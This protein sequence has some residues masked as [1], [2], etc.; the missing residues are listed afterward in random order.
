MGGY[1]GLAP[2]PWLRTG[3]G[4]TRALPSRWLRH[5][6][7]SVLT[8]W[9]HERVGLHQ[10]SPAPDRAG[11]DGPEA[12]CLLVALCDSRPCAGRRCAE[13]LTGFAAAAIGC[14]RRS[15]RAANPV[16]PRARVPSQRWVPLSR[17]RMAHARG[18]SVRHP[19]G[20]DRIQGGA[21]ERRPES[22][23]AAPRSRPAECVRT[24]EI[25]LDTVNPIQGGGSCLLS[26]EANFPVIT[27]IR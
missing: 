3:S 14:S 22:S 8:R 24:E 26:G 4:A 18:T 16:S 11:C 27:A 21:A 12:D 23:A 20:A 13:E 15:G 2:S 6:P 9:F 7:G 1:L 25:T 17:P 19:V 10:G 5:Q